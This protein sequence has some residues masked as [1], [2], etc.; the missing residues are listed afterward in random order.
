MVEVSRLAMYAAIFFAVLGAVLGLIG[1]WL[2]DFWRH[3]IGGKLIITDMIFLATAV[4]VA[5]ITKWLS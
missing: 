3:D 2:E 4:A 1:V 5:A